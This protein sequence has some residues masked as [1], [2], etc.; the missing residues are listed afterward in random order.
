MNF[1][2]IKL[3]KGLYTSAKGFTKSLEE[4]DPSENYIGTELEG[5]DA[6]ERQ[7][8]RFNIKVSGK[9]SDTVSKFF[10]TSDSA[11]LFPEYLARA[12]KV[13]LTDNILD[14]L[15]ATTTVI[16]SLDYRSIECIDNGD[17]IDPNGRINEGAFIPETYIK[18]KDT[19]T[20]L[21][22]N[23]RMLVASYEAVKTQKLD[24]FTVSLK[25]IGNRIAQCEAAQ[26]L[27]TLTEYA[28]GLTYGDSG[29]ITYSDFIELWKTLSPYEMNTV[30]AES[31]MIGNIL[32][33]T[34]FKDA[35]A[36]QNFHGTGELVTPL[37]AK[38][39][40]SHSGVLGT[41]V[42]A[43]DKRYAL[44]KVQLGD[45]VTD[46]D[47]LIDRQLERAT[48]TCTSGFNTI[49]KDAAAVITA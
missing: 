37:G 47:K 8:K 14:D 40:Y 20:Q 17:E 28:K 21:R 41:G 18:T 42:L 4:I 35:N 9:D 49:L 11:V 45:V 38:L 13:G 2:T 32:Q 6:Y 48:V 10:Q 26:A 29:V 22:K 43:L 3:D 25:Q 44:E 12:I 19:L 15:V 33:L 34:E 5:L 16:D 30:V 46:F 31:G 36:G 1:D 23:G 24:L 39:V 7:L 27:Q